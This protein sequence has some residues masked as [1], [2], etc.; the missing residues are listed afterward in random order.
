MVLIGPNSQPIQNMDDDQTFLSLWYEGNEWSVQNDTRLF[1]KIQ[2]DRFELIPYGGARHSYVRY[3]FLKNE[4]SDWLD[5]IQ[6]RHGSDYNYLKRQFMIIFSA[7]L[8]FNPHLDPSGFH[9]LDTA[10][11]RYQFTTVEGQEPPHIYL[12]NIGSKDKVNI[13]L[14]NSNQTGPFI[15]FFV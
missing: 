3:D 15:D 12:F 8:Y 11:L 14:Y 4:L 5:K 1:F 6:L 13:Q 7:V 10:K 2:N 9:C